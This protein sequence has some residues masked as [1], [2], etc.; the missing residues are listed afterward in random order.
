MAFTASL[1]SQSASCI[2]KINASS[3]PLPTKEPE[4]RLAEQQVEVRYIGSALIT[5]VAISTHQAH[6]VLSILRGN[7]ANRTVGGHLALRRLH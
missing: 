4:Q 1:I 7:A 5:N 2:C 3:F 6:Q